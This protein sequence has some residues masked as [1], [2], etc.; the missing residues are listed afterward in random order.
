MQ[1]CTVFRSN[2][3]FQQCRFACYYDRVTEQ[4][5]DAAP[6]LDPQRAAMNAHLA[7]FITDMRA[8][9]DSAETL[10]SRPGPDVPHDYLE[11]VTLAA[12]ASQQAG[13]RAEHM[14]YTAHG[15]GEEAHTVSIPRLARAMRMSVNTLRTRLPGIGKGSQPDAET[16]DAF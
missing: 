9:A 4:P 6:V 3:H 8:L 5:W 7:A 11:A 14:A 2:L 16:F 13:V 10:L 15:A 12:K 1:I